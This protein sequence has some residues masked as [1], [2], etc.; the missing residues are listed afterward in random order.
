MKTYRM[1][2][3][4][5]IGAAMI[6]ASFAE[7]AEESVASAAVELAQKPAS[8]IESI[9]LAVAEAVKN[10]EAPSVVMA[11][12]L[13]ARESWTNAQVAFLYKT[14]LMSSPELSAS[15]AQ[16]VK[17]FQES[18]KSV[19]VAEDASEGMKVL[20]L[21]TSCN[22]DAD[23]VLASI[24]ADHSGIASVNPVA[25]LRDVTAGSTGRRQHPVMPTPPVTSSDN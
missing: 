8:S 9:A 12:V 25:P 4:L 5:L 14:L 3:A 10:G 15:F 7:V 2:A 17:S 18:G 20:A 23:V 24:L 21:L 6:P 19:Q 22:V 16:D 1:F 11:R 13:G